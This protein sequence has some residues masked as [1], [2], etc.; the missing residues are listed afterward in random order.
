MRRHRCADKVG[1]RIEPGANTYVLPNAH[2]P[3]MNSY[4]IRIIRR[5]MEKPDIFTS[6]HMGDHA[7]VRRAHALA[8]SGDLVEVWRGTACVFSGE[9]ALH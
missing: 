5:G 1:N 9:P 6:S 7:A 2:G 4:E 3:I 8:D